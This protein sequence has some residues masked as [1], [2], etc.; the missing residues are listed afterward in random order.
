[1]FFFCISTVSFQTFAACPSNHRELLFR[2]N[3]ASSDLFTDD[4]EALSVNTGSNPFSVNKYSR[5]SDIEDYRQADS[6]FV[7]KLSYPNESLVNE[8]SQT[9]NPTTE[10]IA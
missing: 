5:L 2:H 1:V 6:T 4:A 8:R 7:F 3:V 10:A 9:S